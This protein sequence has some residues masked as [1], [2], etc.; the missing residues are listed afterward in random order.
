MSFLGSPSISDLGHSFRSSLELF[1]NQISSP[2]LAKLALCFQSP[3]ISRSVIIYKGIHLAS[4]LGSGHI[5]ILPLSFL[6]FSLLLLY[7]TI[8]YKKTRL[9]GERFDEVLTQYIIKF[10][11][12]VGSFTAVSKSRCIHINS[13]TLTPIWLS[14]LTGAT[15][16][17]VS[18]P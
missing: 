14:P 4:C 18:R 1:T 13:Y 9:R 10:Y 17:A 3:T 15:C 11:T 8:L 7:C 2:L 12:V 5:S 16:R 6:H